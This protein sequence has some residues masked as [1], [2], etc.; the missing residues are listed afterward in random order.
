MEEGEWRAD[1]ERCDLTRLHGVGIGMLERRNQTGFP[2]SLSELVPTNR[3]LEC[4]ND[5]FR[6]GTRPRVPGIGIRVYLLSGG[7]SGQSRLK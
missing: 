5:S 4:M 3:R 6:R 2:A 1:E 7:T